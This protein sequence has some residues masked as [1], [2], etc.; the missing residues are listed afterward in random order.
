MRVGEAKGDRLIYSARGHSCWVH[1]MA[2]SPDGRHLSSAGSLDPRSSPTI[3]LASVGGDG[4]LKIWDAAS[5]RLAHT[6]R[7]HGNYIRGVAF[8]PDGTRLASASTDWTIKLWDVAGGEEVLT[9][10]G[11]AGGVFGVA[12]SPDGTFLASAGGDGT[13]RIWD[14][15]PW[16]PPSRE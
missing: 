5:G 13:V 6:I 8:S 7:G 15:R 4:N 12:F 3:R 2:F 16:S 10:R 14:V 1:S 9:L 11:H